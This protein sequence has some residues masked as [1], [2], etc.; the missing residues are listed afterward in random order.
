MDCAQARTALH[1]YLDGELDGAQVEAFQRHLA[2]CPE[3][4][5]Q[6]DSQRALSRALRQLVPRPAPAAL[7]SRILE[8]LHPPAAPRR[9]I[10]F[11]GPLRWAGSL[12]ATILITWFVA[13][14]WYGSSSADLVVREVVAAHERSLLPGHLTDVESSD[15]HTVKPWFTGRVEFAPWVQDLAVQGYPLVG[16]RLEVVAGSRVAAL[17]Y[18]R[19]QHLINLFER[20]S[21]GSDAIGLKLTS[22]EGYHLL[23]WSQDGRYFVAISDVAMLDLEG[24]AEAARQAP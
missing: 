19:H 2:T 8:E 4:T 24:F 22:S 23:S 5:R 12:A 16:G 17:V 20:P 18:K 21:A 13:R 7:R 14:I 11:L 6:L 15:H 10:Q 3:C 9:K 1:P